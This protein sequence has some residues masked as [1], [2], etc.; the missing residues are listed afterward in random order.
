MM[1]FQKYKKS[2]TYTSDQ[3]INLLQMLAVSKVFS[4]ETQIVPEIHELSIFFIIF[5]KFGQEKS[6]KNFIQYISMNDSLKGE[7]TRFLT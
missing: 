2:K 4:G 5:M 6:L 3:I 7:Y 1:K